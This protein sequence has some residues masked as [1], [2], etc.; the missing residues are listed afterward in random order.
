MTFN[1]DLALLLMHLINM[2]RV[3]YHKNTGASLEGAS[4]IL[5][6]AFILVSAGVLYYY[7]LSL[8][9]F[10]VKAFS[11][12]ITFAVSMVALSTNRQYI[13]GF[14]AFIALACFFV[15]TIEAFTMVY[16]VKYIINEDADNRITFWFHSA[17]WVF[18]SAFVGA[19]LYTG[20]K[21]KLAV[22][23]LQI[24][25]GIV[26]VAILA[27]PLL[28]TLE[29][30]INQNSYLHVSTLFLFTAWSLSA[31]L[32]SGLRRSYP[33]E[34]IYLTVTVIL[35]NALSTALLQFS[36]DQNGGF[37]AMAVFFR[38]A[39]MCMLL[40]L[41][42][43]H[44]ILHK[45]ESG[46][47]KNEKSD[48]DNAVK[49][50]VDERLRDLNAKNSQLKTIMRQKN[51]AAKEACFHTKNNLQIISSILDLRDDI[52]K[53]H[54]ADI[55][56]K[57]QSI[58]LIQQMIYRSE[59]SRQFEIKSYLKRLSGLILKIYNTKKDININISGPDIDV[60]LDTA[61][62]IGLIS[63]ELIANS[64]QH[65]FPESERGNID[66]EICRRNHEALQITYRDNGKGLPEDFTLETNG[67]YGMRNI[68]SI[69][70]D[71]LRGNMRICKENGFSIKIIILVFHNDVIMGALFVH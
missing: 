48:F 33:S 10:S 8:F 65:A 3:L 1:I 31:L 59:N 21:K 56:A 50:M 25:Y 14:I 47:L 24:A 71:Q 45:K 41:V 27:F 54:H 36:E 70:V 26:S 19:Y 20:I 7:D 30:N 55:Q 23:K 62:P 39:A 44:K 28:I 22:W 42:I 67:S 15:A 35:L 2:N 6:L 29:K 40:W 32:Y 5:P 66:I 13:S 18:L 63:N 51:I 53:K 9:V 34:S 43:N 60:D 64:I 52:P 17:N 61:L 46:V 12:I 68:E 37:S 49:H 69:V 16:S 38:F 58:A 11:V 57:I 4:G